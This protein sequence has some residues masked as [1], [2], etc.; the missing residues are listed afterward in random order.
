M[1]VIGAVALFCSLSFA[2]RNFDTVVVRATKLSDAVWLLTGSGG[3]IGVCSGDDGT[4]II[5]DQFA[6]LTE[7]IKAAIGEIEKVKAPIRFVIN[8][9]WHGDH[10]GGNENMG[11]DGAVIIAHDNVR[12]RM[13]EERFNE[14][15]KTTI[16]GSPKVALPVV[17]FADDITLHFNGDDMLI[18]H[19]NPAHTDGDAVIYF[20]KANI[21]HMGDV[22]FSGTYPF[23][24]ISSGGSIN[25]MVTAVDKILPTIDDATQV[26]PGHGRVA[27][28]SDLRAYRDMLATIRDKVLVLVRKGK[29]LDEVKAEKPTKDFDNQWGGGFVNP[30]RFVETVYQS[31]A[32]K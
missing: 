7:K 31:L 5:D 4:F 28:K 8:T 17:T 22:F 2:Q 32:K 19:V 20:S 9:H 18:S 29:T 26:I 30:D 27:T 24:D 21:I 16:P 23:I 11:K 3:N 10:T 1:F 14:V 12:K 13:S 25:G 6:P 15:A